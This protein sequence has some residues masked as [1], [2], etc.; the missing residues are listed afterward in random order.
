MYWSFAQEEDTDVRKLFEYNLE[1]E[2]GHLHEAIKTLKKMDK[3]DPEELLSKN[4]P[5]PISFHSNIEYMRGIIGSSIDL[6]A[7]GQGYS[8]YR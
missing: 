4:F 7:K 6:T 8:P 5:D 3:K 1:M 2:L